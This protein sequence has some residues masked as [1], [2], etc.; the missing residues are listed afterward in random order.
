VSRPRQKPQG[1]RHGKPA[2]PKAFD[3]WAPPPPLPEARPVPRIDDP[4]VVTALLRS[5][6]DPPLSARG[7]PVEEYLCR[8]VESAARMAK[9]L[10]LS[11]NLL[12]EPDDED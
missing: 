12:A 2:G 6:G 5:L 9:G 7:L 1:R 10:A 3:V 11:V 8:A 4:V